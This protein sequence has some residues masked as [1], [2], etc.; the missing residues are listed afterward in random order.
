MS[1]ATK[2]TKFTT[3][4]RTQLIAE[5]MERNLTVQE[6]WAKHQEELVKAE[7]KDSDTLRDLLYQRSNML[8]KELNKIVAK[9]PQI[10]KILGDKSEKTEQPRKQLSSL[11]DQYGKMGFNVLA[12]DSEY[13]SISSRKQPE[14]MSID[15]ILDMLP[16]E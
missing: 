16:S 12:R 14:T 7:V 5:A 15:D 3:E 2:F 11:L 10:Q 4:R 13:T 8:A 6:L 9:K 1:R